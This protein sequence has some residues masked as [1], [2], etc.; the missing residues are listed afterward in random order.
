[1][2]LIA[3]FFVDYGLSFVHLHRFEHHLRTLVTETVALERRDFIKIFQEFGE[4]YRSRFLN[5]AVVLLDLKLRLA[6]YELGVL[7]PTFSVAWIALGISVLLVYRLA[8]A[9]TG[10]RPAAL[11]GTCVYVTTT[12]FLSVITM[13]LMPG[14]PLSSFAII[15]GLSL[16]SRLAHL[17]QPGRLVHETA[18]ATKYGLWGLMFTALL[19]DEVPMFMIVALPLLFSELFLGKSDKTPR[20][21]DIARAA[22]FY[23]VP[24]CAFLVFV[25]ILVPLITR[26]YHNYSFDYL[27]TLIGYGPRAGGAKSLFEGP[28]G[29]F[30]LGTL[31]T[32]FGTLFGLSLIPWQLSPLVSHQGTSG[33]LNSQATSWQQLAILLPVLSAIV[34]LAFRSPGQ[35]GRYF[36]LMIIVV[37]L[38]VLF[39]SLL[40]A[41][42]VPYISGYYY[43]S[44]FSGL[45]ALLVAFSLAA[46][47]RVAPRWRAVSAML[48]LA[49]VIVQ[50]DNFYPI[51]ESW[52]YVHNEMM[53]RPR[54]RDAIILTTDERR[55][56]AAELS[57]IWQAWR[58]GELDH[59]LR[60]H[61]ASTGA[62][63]MI[64]E[65]RW[66]DHLRR[67]SATKSGPLRRYMMKTS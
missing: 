25:L 21:R 6:F 14:K 12:G 53:D 67:V 46:L 34:W 24:V 63:F 2:A 51:N 11:L 9:L 28:Y 43:G 5:Y 62:I 41:R 22:L 49:V 29:G 4:E 64:V 54:H 30:T 1:M 44:A 45:F 59:H 52:I 20:K 16:M 47:N 58:R 40:N 39:E 8:A 65:L 50:I 57:S 35:T 15:C 38:S 32:N 48:A 61:P 23:S 13:S 7:H 3:P 31:L 17:A 36:R 60:S 37:A 42:H 18:G 66:L 26:H 33:I 27:S 55:V 10:D 19:L 56:T